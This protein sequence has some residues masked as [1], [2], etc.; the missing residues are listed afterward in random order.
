[1]QG[2]LGDQRTKVIDLTEYFGSK[3][4]PIKNQM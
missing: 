2:N 3:L 1:L 4:A